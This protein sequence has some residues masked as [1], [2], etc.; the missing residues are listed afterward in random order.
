MFQG[1]RHEFMNCFMLDICISQCKYRRLRSSS[2]L[3]SI[4][5]S[6]N[7]PPTP[8]HIPYILESNP[9]PFYNFRLLKIQMRITIARG[10]ES[11]LRAGFWKYD[12]AAVRAVRT[13][14]YN[15]LF[16]LFIIIIYSSDSPS[17][18]ITESLSVLRRDCARLLR[19]SRFTVPV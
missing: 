1:Y 16:Y 8:F 14:Q 15:N 7:Q 5:F 13:I 4:R 2:I 17:S 10:S 3:R 9:H 18:P 6:D 19:K 12:G 11:R